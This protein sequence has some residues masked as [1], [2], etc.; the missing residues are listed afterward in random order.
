MIQ[1]VATESRQ[2]RCHDANSVDK[3]YL[4]GGLSWLE[5]KVTLESIA[6]CCT[7]DRNVFL[8]VKKEINANH[9]DTP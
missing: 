1:K 4:C 5:D 9:S 3:M 7:N 2:Y 6:T 8:E